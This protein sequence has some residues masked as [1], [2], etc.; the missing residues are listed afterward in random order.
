MC[1]IHSHS[2]S[3][4][5]PVALNRPPTAAADLVYDNSEQSTG[6]SVAGDS[7]S[8]TV[9][10][11]SSDTT[12]TPP[13]TDSEGSNYYLLQPTPLAPVESPHL[14]YAQVDP[15]KQTQVQPP[16]NDDPVQYAQIEHQD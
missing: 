6:R 12:T 14:V 7:E 2:P 11:Q 16:A 13:S 15:V 8:T 4:G 9:W 3:L 1:Y 10:T 5:G